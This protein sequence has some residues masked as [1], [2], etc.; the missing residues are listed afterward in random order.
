MDTSYC[1]PK[2][3]E[4]K[5]T[6]NHHIVKPVFGKRIAEDMSDICLPGYR[7]Y[8]E[9]DYYKRFPNKAH[10]VELLDFYDNVCPGENCSKR[11]LYD[12]KKPMRSS[13]I[14]CKLGKE[15]TCKNP[16]HPDNAMFIE[17]IN[18]LKAEEEAFRKAGI[19]EGTVTYTCPKCGSEAIA[20]R[21][22]HGGR[23][24]GLGSYCKKCGTSHT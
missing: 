5:N 23:Y 20:N 2:H 17:F 24:H 18:T 10:Y 14:D 6:C 7:L 4:K 1:N 21:Y 19:D 12:R 15:Y 13:Q 8:I 3:C 11:E 16:K 22:K 9:G